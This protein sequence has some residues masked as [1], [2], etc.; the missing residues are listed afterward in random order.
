MHLTN[1]AINK[2]NSKFI[3]NRNEDYDDTGHKRSFTYI[4]KYLEEKGED[5]KNLMEN[6]K[7]TIIKT[8]C[9]V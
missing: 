1:Y 4:L 8:I 7:N 6:I 9:T 5:V 3:H 2:T